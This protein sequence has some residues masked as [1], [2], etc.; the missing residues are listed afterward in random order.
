MHHGL[1]LGTFTKEGKH[2]ESLK[3]RM[4]DDYP[5]WATALGELKYTRPFIDTGRKKRTR[6]VKHLLTFVL[7]SK[8][9]SDTQQNPICPC[10]L[11][12][13]V[14]LSVIQKHDRAGMVFRH[15]C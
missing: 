9:N 12:F 8:W 5:Y 13:L 14:V 15:R 2:P 10:T 3:L 4:V 6:W 11:E 1:L 7:R